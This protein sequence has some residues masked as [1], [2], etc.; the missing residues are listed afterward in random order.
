MEN[1]KIK[2]ELE[3][4][5]YLIRQRHKEFLMSKLQALGLKT[6]SR[7]TVLYAVFENE[8]LVQDEISSKLSMDKAFVTRELNALSEMGLV[9]RLK[10]PQDHRRNHIFLTDEGRELGEAIAKIEEDWLAIAYKGVALKDF[11]VMKGY[12]EHIAANI[13]NS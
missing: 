13:P 6:S 2:D 8:G 12:A 7:G 4:L 9:Y 3:S 1:R 5:V 11:D 10:D